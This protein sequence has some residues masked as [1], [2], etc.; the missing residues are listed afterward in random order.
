MDEATFFILCIPHKD[1]RFSSGHPASAP[2]LYAARRHCGRVCDLN[3][4]LKTASSTSCP[5][6]MPKAGEEK[7]TTNMADRHRAVIG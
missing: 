4:S 2:A 3:A 5:K 6:V 7:Q 1:D